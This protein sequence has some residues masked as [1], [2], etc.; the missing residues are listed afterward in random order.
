MVLSILRD[1]DVEWPK[2]TSKGRKHDKSSER[3]GKE[4]LSKRM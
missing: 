2:R 4:P 3:Y 1:F